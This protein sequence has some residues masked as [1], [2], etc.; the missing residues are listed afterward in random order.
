MTFG[1]RIAVVQGAPSAAIEDVFRVLVDRWR[2]TMRLAGVLA[3]GHGLADRA[4]S[5]GFLHSLGSDERFSVF[6]DAGPNS[7]ACHLEGDG[8]LA[9]AEAVC[10]DIDRGCD[11]VVLSKFGK[12]EA[13]GDGL[14]A[15]FAAAIAAGVPVLTSVS[16]KFSAAWDAFAASSFVVL[17]AD[18]DRIEQWR[19][20]QEAVAQR[21]SARSGE[22]SGTNSR[23]S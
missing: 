11:L 17:P 23:S 3:E 18:P 9:A 22:F 13:K 21:R 15:A 20:D 5:A 14:Y 1:S 6:Q 19:C 7:T 4:C 2:P 8:M 10:R 16:G 12:L